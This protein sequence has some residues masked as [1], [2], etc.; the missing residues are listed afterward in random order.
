MLLLLL[1]RLLK[2]TMFA[3]HA[4]AAGAQESIV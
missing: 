3:S 4:E 2:S 1:K